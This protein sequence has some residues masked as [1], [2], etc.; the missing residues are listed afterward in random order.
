MVRSRAQ[1][2][3]RRGPSRAQHHLLPGEQQ[4][5]AQAAANS[6]SSKQREQA[7]STSSKQQ[8]QRDLTF[9][10]TIESMYSSWRWELTRTPWLSSGVP[11]S[12][13]HG[14]SGVSRPLTSYR[15]T[16]RSCSL[17]SCAQSRRH[18]GEQGSFQQTAK[19]WAKPALLGPKYTR[20]SP[21]RGGS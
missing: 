1:C 21:Y 11:R 9:T 14:S 3:S 13:R 10:R 12:W 7:A 5:A 17:G 8:H 18:R 16:R 6:P 2:S 20:S 15:T 4:Q 19:V